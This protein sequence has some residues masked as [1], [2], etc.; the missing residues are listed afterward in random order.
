MAFLEE[1][2]CLGIHELPWAAKPANAGAKSKEVLS[3]GARHATTLALVGID[4]NQKGIPVGVGEFVSLQIGA[5]VERA[6]HF[7]AVIVLSPEIFYVFQ[8]HS[9]AVGARL[10][11]QLHS[12][13]LTATQRG[14]HPCITVLPHAI[15]S[16]LE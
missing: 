11:L 8:N 5:V 16:R 3:L 2:G 9:L 13:H 7:E 6:V 14:G 10:A 12:G 15:V 1:H 4:R